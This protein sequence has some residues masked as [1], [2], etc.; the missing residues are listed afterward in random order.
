MTRAHNGSGALAGNV[1]GARGTGNGFGVAGKS[2]AWGMGCGGSDGAQ[3]MAGSRPRH[4]SWTGGIGARAGLAVGGDGANEADKACGGTRLGTEM[5][6]GPGGTRGVGRAQG[7]GSSG[8][9]SIGSSRAQGRSSR[10]S[11]TDFGRAQAFGNGSG[12]TGGSG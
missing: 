8:T 11:E 12:G 10:C 9:V 4:R 7:T 3:G 6:N 2:W 5:G 1:N